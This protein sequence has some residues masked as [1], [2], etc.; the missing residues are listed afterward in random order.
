MQ[1]ADWINILRV[2][3][4]LKIGTQKVKKGPY[5]DP[6]PKIGT[7]WGTV[8]MWYISS[9]EYRVNIACIKSR[10]I[11]MVGLVAALQ[12]PGQNWHLV[13]MRKNGA[14]LMLLMR[15]LSTGT[16]DHQDPVRAQRCRLDCWGA[17]LLHR[18]H[19]WRLLAF[20]AKKGMTWMVLF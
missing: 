10:S 19:H 11:L 9:F 15:S 18:W 6:V 4:T 16:C 1:S 3:K 5:R 2:A 20:E 7:L 13:M 17:S 8:N 12:W 14:S